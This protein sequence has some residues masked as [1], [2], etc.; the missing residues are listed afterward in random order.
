M[1]I[2]N[3]YIH[4]T[5]SIWRVCCWPLLLL[6]NRLYSSRMAIKLPSCAL[7][8]HLM[9]LDKNGSIQEWR[10]CMVLGSTLTLTFNVQYKTGRRYRPSPM[11]VCVCFGLYMYR[12]H[13]PCI[14]YYITHIQCTHTTYTYTRMCVITLCQTLVALD[15]IRRTL[16]WDENLY[17]I[18]IYI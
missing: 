13:W 10:K 3:K 14:E 15:K 6:E 16:C 12:I 11:A 4:M 17:I 8:G 9:R 18:D 2:Y 5:A 7:I 1:I